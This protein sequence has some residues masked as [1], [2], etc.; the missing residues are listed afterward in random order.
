MNFVMVGAGAVGGYFGGKLARA[1]ASV[2]FLVR[3]RRF[4]E[5]RESG[6][7]IHS[8]HGDFAVTPVLA[9]NATAIT[10]PHVAMVAVKN[11]QLESAM[12]QLAALVE[13][14][15]KLLPLLNG[16]LHIDRLTQAF[17]Q[18]A[19][20]GGCCYVEATLNPEGD[21]LQTSPMQDIIF[22]PLSIVDR[23]FLTEIESWLERA[24]IAGKLSPHI[25]VDMWTKYL[26]LATL[27]GITTATRLPVG[28]IRED[29]VA[30]EFLKGMIA[31]AFAVAKKYAPELPDDLPETLLA[32]LAAVAPT[33]TS[34]MHRDLEKDLPL[35]LDDLQGALITLGRK[36]GLDTPRFDAIYALLHPYRHGSETP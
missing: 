34:S 11:Y 28:P 30:Y 29:P 32:R 8:V 12:P 22:G 31:E 16:V 4:Q 17:G 19:V 1:G 18:D 35:E 6:L 36:R 13:R 2:T 7:R 15:A 21:I 33:M 5:L 3:E 26:F 10:D 24:G 27:S 14:G 25:M 9:T 20:L 23:S